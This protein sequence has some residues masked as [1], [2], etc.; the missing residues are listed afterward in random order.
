VCLIVRFFASRYE[1][2]FWLAL[3]GYVIHLFAFNWWDDFFNTLQ[4]RNESYRFLQIWVQADS[5]KR[6]FIV[7]IGAS[8]SDLKSWSKGLE[9]LLY[10]SLR[11]P[12][13]TF[14]YSFITDEKTFYQNNDLFSDWKDRYADKIEFILYN[15]VFAP[16]PE[17]AYGLNQCENGIAAACSDIIRLVTLHNPSYD[18]NVYM[19]IDT[20]IHRR[21][22]AKN[23]FL[24]LSP[25]SST[26]PHL[27]GLN[28]TQPGLA[29]SC[30]S[31]VGASFDQSSLQINNDFL[32]DYQTP[33]WLWAF[34]QS[35]GFHRLSQASPLLDLLAQRSLVTSFSSYQEHLERKVQYALNNSSHNMNQI[36]LVIATA[37]PGLWKDLYL[38]NI[39]KR[40]DLPIIPSSGGWMNHGGTVYGL[41]STDDL[42]LFIDDS[43]TMKTMIALNFLSHDY[44]YYELRHAYWISDLKQ[45]LISKLDTLSPRSVEIGKNLFSSSFEWLEEI[46]DA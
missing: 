18:Y 4:Q 30:F 42:S 24:A 15:D 31:L 22:S 35:I 45:D 20:F 17:L 25:F 21:K 9:R 41:T 33:D 10:Q 29:Q 36:P 14:L 19:D 11:Y 37:G 32:I 8:E 40:Y 38:R 13:V 26:S 12:D 23:P 44:Y 16:Y 2:S 39:S 7:A 5:P 6:P 28:L 3:Y 1:F 43:E 27:F 34:V 46:K